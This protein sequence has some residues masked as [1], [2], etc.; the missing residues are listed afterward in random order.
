MRQS[1]PAIKTLP[2]DN[3]GP[4]SFPILVDPQASGSQALLLSLY[5]PGLGEEQTVREARMSSRLW[6]APSGGSRTIGCEVMRIIGCKANEGE[7]RAVRGAQQ[8]PRNHWLQSKLIAVAL[9]SVL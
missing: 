2:Q 9:I 5:L 3:L 7:F 6:V 4:G 8:V 1:C